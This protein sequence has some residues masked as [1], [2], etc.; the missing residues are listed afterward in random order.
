MASD[1][2]VEEAISTARR[3]QAIAHRG[4]RMQFPENSLVAFEGA[5][6]AGANAIETDLH[7][8]RDGVVVISH[9][10]TLKRCFGMDKKIIDCD[11][12]YIK[13]LRTLREPHVPL[14]TL[15]EVLE[16]LCE[17]AAQKTWLLLDIKLD[18]DAA[19]MMRLTAEV[20]KSVHPGAEHWKGRIVLGC[21]RLKYVPLCQKYL[22][23]FHIVHI[24]TALPYAWE[25]LKFP[26]VGFNIFWSLLQTSAGKK[27]VKEA[28]DSNRMVY[29]WTINDEDTMKYDLLVAHIVSDNNRLLGGLSRATL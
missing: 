23:G 3:T 26:G 20:I 4:F 17:P 15:K 25:F 29:V 27:F 18:D 7:L 13:T 11:I 21:W 9:D 19:D 5:V 22:P 12:A 24:G 28:K 8:S 14:P 1:H 16:F 6:K 10:A 2:F